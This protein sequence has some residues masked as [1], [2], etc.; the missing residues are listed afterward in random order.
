MQTVIVASIVLIALG[1]SLPSLWWNYCPKNS[2]RN[3][4]RMVGSLGLGM[5]RQFRLICR[6][7][8]EAAPLERCSAASCEGTVISG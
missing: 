5:S 2:W 1:A 6:G 4:R 7:R 8:A 3:P